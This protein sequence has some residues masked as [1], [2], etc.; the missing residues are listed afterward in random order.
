MINFYIFNTNYFKTKIKGILILY[1]SFLP[2]FILALDW[3]RWQH[4][5]FFSLFSI[6]LGDEN[7]VTNLKNIQT[8]CLI[9]ILPTFFMYNPHCCAGFSLRNIISYNL[10]TFHILDFFINL[11]QF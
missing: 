4:I 6:Y 7:K 10:D 1:I 11:Y 5:L 9:F 3:G 8:S 2:L